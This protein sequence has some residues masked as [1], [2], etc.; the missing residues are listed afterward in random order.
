LVERYHN[1]AVAVEQQ[2]GSSPL[3]RDAERH[4][5]PRRRKGPIR[6]DRVKVERISDEKSVILRGSRFGAIAP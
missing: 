5:D 6:V 2:K 1:F 4:C 3:R